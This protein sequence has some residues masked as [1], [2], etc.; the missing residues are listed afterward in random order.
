MLLLQIDIYTF[1]SNLLNLSSLNIMSIIGSVSVRDVTHHQRDIQL[2]PANN[3][4]YLTSNVL[5]QTLVWHTSFSGMDLLL[6]D[7]LT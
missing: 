6:T 3:V 1:L 5:L 7:Q 2:S 4:G